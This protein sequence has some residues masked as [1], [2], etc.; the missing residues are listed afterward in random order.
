[1]KRRRRHKISHHCCLLPRMSRGKEIKVFKRV[2]LILSI[3]L[4]LPFAARAQ[5][6]VLF[7]ALEDEL[8]RTTEKLKMEK[9]PPPYYV[10]YRVEDCERLIIEASFGAITASD[11]SKEKNLHLDLRVGDYEFDNSNFVS[12]TGF[13]FMQRRGWNGLSLPVEDDYDAIRYKIWLATDK[14]YKRALE[15]LSRKKATVEN[16]LIKD[17]PADFTR[18]KPTSYEEPL[19][20]FEVNQ[21]EL[22]GLL[23][24]LSRVFRGFKEIQMSKLKL[25]TEIVHQYFVDSEGSKHICN[26]PLTYLEVY[27]S[28]QSAD[29]NVLKD[30]IGFYG[31][32]VND[33]PDKNVLRNRIIEF[34]RDFSNTQTVAKSEEY[35]GPVLFTDDACGQLFYEIIGRGLSNSRSPL[36]ESEQYE[37]MSAADEGFLADKLG[38]RVLPTS[39]SVYDDPRTT[40]WGNTSLIGC[41]QVDDQGVLAQ[42]VDLIK[43]GKIVAF[44]M[45]R[46][47]TKEIKGLNGH[48]RSTGDSPAGR[49]ANLIVENTQVKRG[50]ME[51]FI[52]LLKDRELEYGV[53]VTRLKGEMPKETE[54]M[55]RFFFSSFTGKEEKDLLS[56]PVAGYRLYQDGHTEP[57]RGL[58]FEGVSYRTLRDIVLSSKQEVV[59]SFLEQ[60]QFGGELPVSVV[61]PAVVVDEMDLVEAE[62][63]PKKLPVVP[64][65]YFK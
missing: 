18:V 29:G 63:K 27:V 3:F 57:I 5:E 17:R 64:H 49:V 13:S 31:Q 1:M 59:Y 61:A 14:A 47:P 15:E 34:A 21:E 54:E 32:T 56:E 25:K 52:K 9:M 16:R 58:K 11:F 8:A 28:T 2:S 20:K 44:P 43:S 40:K 53:V 38:R 10:A 65:P 62:T 12:G 6:S 22:E 46:T 50:I 51:E 39:F 60:G 42:K 41:F 48:A 23:V 26:K 24:E 55:V 37:K 4:V 7:K 33:L 36:Y 30:M 35:V 19:M 45:S